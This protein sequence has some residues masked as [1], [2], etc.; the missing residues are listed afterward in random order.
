VLWRKPSVGRAG[1]SRVIL[2]LDG[3]AKEN[4]E[5]NRG[6]GVNG[7]VEVATRHLVNLVNNEGAR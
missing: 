1:V 2:A 3:V 4:H 6:V 7:E 5:L